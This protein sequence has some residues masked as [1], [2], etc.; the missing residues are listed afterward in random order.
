MKISLK[1]TAGGRVLKAKTAE[2]ATAHDLN[3]LAREFG[4]KA[5]RATVVDVVKRV[6][7]LRQKGSR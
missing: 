3:T 2:G 4:E 1:L 7:A 6:R 5:M